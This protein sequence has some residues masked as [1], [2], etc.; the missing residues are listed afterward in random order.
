MTLPSASELRGSESAPGEPYG[1]SASYLVGGSGVAWRGAVCQGRVT[2]DVS[3]ACGVLRGRE[4]PKGMQRRSAPRHVDTVPLGELHGIAV[5]VD[6]AL[7]H[8][9]VPQPV[10]AVLGP[11]AR[12]PRHQ[13]AQARH[14]WLR[15]GAGRGS[16]LEHSARERRQAHGRVRGRVQRYLAA[17]GRRAACCRAAGCGLGTE[18][19]GWGTEGCGRGEWAGW[20]GA[21]R[22]GYGDSARRDLT[23]G[24]LSS[25]ATDGRCSGLGCSRLVMVCTISAGRS[26]GSGANSPFCMAEVEE[27]ACENVTI[28]YRMQPRAW[29]VRVTVRVRVRD[30]REPG[31][32]HGTR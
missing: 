19:C 25:S 27:N 24:R 5:G 31:G 9:T 13:H 20:G 11:H 12:P 22:T 17:C 30:S 15:V 18:G 23:A 21:S 14:S 28:S 7:H 1:R 29:K 8:T 6:R 16:G 3:R 2:C 32:A 26:G 10:A 4:A